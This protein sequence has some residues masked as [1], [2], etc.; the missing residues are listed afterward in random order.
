MLLDAFGLEKCCVAGG[1]FVKKGY[2]VRM[3]N[4]LSSKQIKF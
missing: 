4:W 2:Y 1:I 3:R